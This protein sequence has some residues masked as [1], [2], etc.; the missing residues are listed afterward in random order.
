[1][2]C[3]SVLVHLGAVASVAEPKTSEKRTILQLG[4]TD[5]DG[6]LS[7]AELRGVVPHAT[8]AL[9]KRLDTDSDGRLSTK[10]WN[11]NTSRTYPN[12]NFP[13]LFRADVDNNQKVTFEEAISKYELMTP[14]EFIRLDADGD[15]AITR[16]EYSNTFR[17]PQGDAIRRAID[18][19]LR[20]DTDGDGKASWEEIRARAPEYPLLVFQWLDRNADNAI[21]E[22]DYRSGEAAESPELRTS[23]RRP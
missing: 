5:G 18:Y 13:H 16:G 7:F 14:S 12:N 6:T 19:F 8:D 9:F 3:A 2:C 20:A 4:D 21:T 23:P 22:S 1:M 15:G 17:R 10:D 11:W